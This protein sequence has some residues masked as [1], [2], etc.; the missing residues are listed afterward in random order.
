MRLPIR[1]GEVLR[2]AAL[3]P[4]DHHLTPAA[5]LRFGGLGS[6]EIFHDEGFYAFRSI[7]Y[8]DYI[9]NDD[10]TTPIQ[11]FKD[12][13]SLPWWTS[14]S[15]HDH[16]PLFFLIQNIFF[17]I[18]GNSLFAARLPSA[19]AGVFSIYLVYLISSSIFGTSDVLKT[20][21][22]DVQELRSQYSGHRESRNRTSDF[23]IAGL[24]AAFL[25]SVNLI[26]IWISRSSLF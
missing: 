8:V 19:L 9:Q 20:R 18:F 6:S 10:Q 14:L 3:E 21:T 26:H 15:F 4:E 23:H 22:P 16:P 25:L 2:R 7:G 17:K 5:I 12:A 24:L 13:P 1:R 11:W